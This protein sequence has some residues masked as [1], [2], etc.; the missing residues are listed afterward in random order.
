MDNIF[1]P[2]CKLRTPVG[3]TSKCAVSTGTS[4][5]LSAGNFYSTSP[6]LYLVSHVRSKGRKPL[7]SGR[8]SARKFVKETSFVPERTRFGYY[9]RATIVMKYR[10]NVRRR[11][12]FCTK[13]GQRMAVSTSGGK[14][15]REP[16]HISPAN[17]FQ[18]IYRT[19]A[20]SGWTF[21]QKKWLESRRNG[22]PPSR[23]MLVAV[24]GFQISVSQTF[25]R[26]TRPRCIDV[27]LHLRLLPDQRNSYGCDRIKFTIL[28]RLSRRTG[29][30][31]NNTS[32]R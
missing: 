18:G 30:T 2:I 27:R 12:N 14:A 15:E 3:E 5:K 6:R 10:R 1:L 16:N 7:R 25:R 24:P 31:L 23:Q 9:V 11:R 20:D 17:F 8:D 28:P 26:R 22:K 21:E 19:N 13:E 4:M 32:G 29:N